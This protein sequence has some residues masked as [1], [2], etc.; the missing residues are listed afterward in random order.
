MKHHENNQPNN[1]TSSSPFGQCIKSKRI[2][3]ENDNIHTV[4]PNLTATNVLDFAT[5]VAVQ[6][7]TKAVK[8]VDKNQVLANQVLNLPRSR[9]TSNNQT[10]NHEKVTFVKIDDDQYSNQ[11]S[12]EVLEKLHCYGSTI[13]KPVFL[14]IGYTTGY[15]VW[16]VSVDGDAYEIVSNRSGPVNHAKILPTPS[17]TEVRL[18]NRESMTNSQTSSVNSQITTN[19]STG[20][21][22]KK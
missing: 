12:I 6:T 19:S 14:Y 3:P 16:L 9:N 20:C 15:S 2:M 17:K 5:K 22:C 10:P 4:Y 18:S 13:K 8:T 11:S 7:T 1:N 21:F